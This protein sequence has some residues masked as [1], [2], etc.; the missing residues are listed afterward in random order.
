[1]YSS[2]SFCSSSVCYCVAR[3]GRELH[4]RFPGMK[5]NH[6]VW[7]STSMTALFLYSKLH[8]HW[9]K[10]GNDRKGTTKPFK[11]SRAWDPASFL[12]HVFDVWFTLTPESWWILYCPYNKDAAL[13]HLVC[14]AICSLLYIIHQRRYHKRADRYTHRNGIPLF[15]CRLYCCQTDYSW[16][17]RLTFTKDVAAWC[18]PL[19]PSSSAFLSS[20]PGSSSQLFFFPERLFDRISIV[21]QWKRMGD[22]E[23]DHFSL[24]LLCLSSL[25]FLL[26]TR[27]VRSSATTALVGWIFSIFLDMSIAPAN[28]SGKLYAYVG[29][30]V[31]YCLGLL[32]ISR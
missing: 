14:L 30:R 23:N 27:V 21:H 20:Y 24:Q 3:L 19:L 16:W 13:P 4:V 31:V 15:P 26:T 1:M 7:L 29:Y 6:Q 17:W 25:S 18:D 8:R 32:S 22:F 5:T 28:I 10:T 9:L 11:R 12:Q 2:N